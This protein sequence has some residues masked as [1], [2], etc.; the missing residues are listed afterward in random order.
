MKS[1]LCL[2]VSC[3]IVLFAGC[4]ASPTEGHSSFLSKAEAAKMKELELVPVQKVWKN[5][6]IDTAHYKKL[7]V[8]PVVIPEQLKRST[9]EKTNVRNM[10]GID[11]GDMEDLAKYLRQ[12]IIKA[13]KENKVIE[14][15]DKPG[16]NT[17][18]IQLALVKVVP[19]KPI[20]GALGNLG[21]LTPI[22]F[23]ISPIK[24]SVQGST[25]NAMQASVAIEGRITDS[26]T[27]KTVAVF[28][29]RRK[30]RAAFFNFNDFTSHGNLRQISDEWALQL[31]KA[32]REKPLSTGKKIESSGPVTLFNY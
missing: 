19:G 23:I 18:A 11:S 3:V 29:D 4:K 26:Q 6:K 13:V 27:G 1:L 14:L 21:N 12:A 22:G 17:V 31:V 8:K 25:D 32:L 20:A 15:A 2:A 16:P 30:Q 10:L 9:M 5:P 24:V 7:M 28:A